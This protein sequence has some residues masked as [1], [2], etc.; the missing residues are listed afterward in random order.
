[1]KRSGNVQVLDSFQYVPIIETL[2][3]VRSNEN[4]L[5]YI[6]H[7][8]ISTDDFIK[9]YRD[10]DSFKEN[11]FFQKYPDAILLQLYFDEFLVNNPLGSKTH[12]QKLGDFYFSILNLPPHLNYYIGNVH[13]LAFCYNAD[14]QK[15]GISRFLEPFMFDLEKLESESGVKVKINKEDFVLRASIATVSADTLAAHELFGLLSPSANLFCRDCMISRHELH[16]V[17]SD[18]LATPRTKDLYQKH[19]DDATHKRKYDTCTTGILNNSKYFHCTANYNFDP[20]HDILDGIGCYR[21]QDQ[22][23]SC[24][25]MVSIE[26]FSLFSI[27]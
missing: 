6:K 5:E 12:G 15:Y 2:K 7:E 11:R 8:P 10:G 3:L 18:F 25:D 9:S 13:V 17:G 27:R 23:K 14:I 1:M 21:T 16:E 19:V 22:R 26:N 4:L 24:T 20:M